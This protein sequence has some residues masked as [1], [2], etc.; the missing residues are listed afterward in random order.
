MSDSDVERMPM[1]VAGLSVGGGDIRLPGVAGLGA[2]AG[3]DEGGG[4]GF[5]GDD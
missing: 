4:D 3:D 2:V 5:K 1:G